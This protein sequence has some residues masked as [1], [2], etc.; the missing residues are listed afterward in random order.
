MI[1]RASFVLGMFLFLT[2]AVYPQ[3]TLEQAFPNLTF[4]S[5]VDFQII[6]GDETDRLF[7]VSQSGIIHVFQ[8]DKN[9]ATSKQFLN[10]TD[11]VSSGGE[12]GLLGLAFHPNYQM[13]GYFYVNYTISS[14]SRQTRISRFSVSAT[15]PDSADK[16]SE[17]ILFSF[18][19]P[20]TNHNG[21]QLA[22]GPDGY[23]YIATGDG[24]SGGD[25]Q[26]YGQTLTTML[27]KILR[28]DVNTPQAPLLYGI[29]P[30]NP[31][32]NDNTGKT[33]EIYAYGMRNPW[34]MSFDPVT[35]WLWAADVGQV[36]REEID[37]IVNG[38]NY[39]WKVME[40]F[41][42]YS[43]STGC[44]TSGKI[45]PIWDYPRSQGYSVT[46]GY[47]YR[48]PN[49][50][51]LVGKYIYGDY[52]SKH[53]WALT[54]NGTGPAQNQ[55]L[56]TSSG[57]SM[58]A[59]GVDRYGELYICDLSGG[60]IWKF[61]PTAP[62]VAPTRLMITGGGPGSVQLSWQDNAANESGYIIES[63]TGSGNWI[64]LDTTA[65]NVTA[66]THSGIADTA[67]I[68]YR[69]RGINA[70][71]TSGY[72][73]VVST[74]PLVPVELTSFNAMLVNGVVQL[75]WVT[76]SETNNRGFEVQKKISGEWLT[77]GFVEGAGTSTDNK[78]YR[79]TDEI[80]FSGSGTFAYRLR[81]VDYDGSA[82]FSNEVEVVLLN[83]ATD[84]ELLQNFPNPFNPATKIRFTGA[85]QGKILVTITDVLGRQVAELVNGDYA[86][87]IHEVIW[88]AS[89]VSSGIYFVNLFAQANGEGVLKFISSAK[90]VY[91][92]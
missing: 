15:N 23:L 87:G 81:Q 24:G 11:R 21:G 38:G 92:K 6:P 27:G 47:V 77:I 33:K 69:V 36:S 72:S 63:K 25:P 66:F 45:L 29:P 55:T 73:N 51:G 41:L 64:S 76:A 42:C 75:D 62:V 48:G 65:A 52:G 28:I 89:A 85:V 67:R 17:L 39:G 83:S 58:S 16:N 79:Y 70:Q 26:N 31:F 53:I 9:A 35:G 32:A 84:F 8:N 43:P 86:A 91:M 10:I 1:K 90:I 34:R 57:R 68:Y 3:Y 12:M 59:F 80:T 5:P 44:D 74:L 56:I 18:T 14:P 19:Q 54:Y 61:V 37:I 30:T 7:V 4:T 46:G 60:K 88:D 13:N 82:S 20:Y 22:F 78:N 40:G 2:A 71:G 50:P 49:Q